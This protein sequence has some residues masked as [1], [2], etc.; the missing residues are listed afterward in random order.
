MVVLLVTAALLL[1]SAPNATGVPTSAWATDIEAYARDYATDLDEARRRLQLQARVD[2]AGAL[3]D[4]AEP[5]AYGGHWLEH[6]PTFKLVVAVKVGHGKELVE[7]Y[8]A[9]ISSEV[10]VEV[11]AVDHSLRELRQ[12]VQELVGLQ[13]DEFG[14][15]AYIDLEGNGVQVRV[16]DTQEFLHGV[17]ARN[18]SLPGFV[19]IVE[20]GGLAAPT[21]A[22]YGGRP[23]TTCTSGFSVRSSS[24]GVDGL[25]TAKHCGN[26]Q[27]YAPTG[28]ALTFM[29]ENG[30]T[31]HDEQWHTRSG[32]TF[33]NRAW[34]GNPD[35]RWITGKRSRLYQSV[36]DYVC[37]WGMSTGYGCGNIASRDATLCGGSGGYTGILV[38]NASNQDLASPGDSGGP[39]YIGEIALGTTSCAS[40]VEPYGYIDAIYVASNYVEGGLNVTIKT[41]P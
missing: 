37:H 1:A 10:P 27:T 6:A 32:A 3:I 5:E 34:D 17:S 4:E 33:P 25:T 36:G 19:R 22:M 24:L 2:D 21:T 9:A 13:S 18:F 11:R 29:A 23:L 41:T 8:F 28:E 40:W 20:V 26:T 12:L 31:G 38:H 15:D 7:R 39:W 14:F 30:T 35:W 16:L